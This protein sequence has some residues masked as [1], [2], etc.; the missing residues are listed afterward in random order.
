M[1][2]IA[3]IRSRVRGGVP[4]DA[5]TGCQVESVARKTTRDGKPYLDVALADATDR[6]SLRVWSDHP[7]FERVSDFERGVFIAVGGEFTVGPFGL[8]ARRWRLRKLE[9]AEIEALVGGSPELRGR[10]ERDFA[11]IQALIAG[12]ADP[13][14]RG[15]GTLFLGEHGA[16]FRRSAAARSYHHAR[17]GGLV[18]HTAQM[19]RCADAVARVYPQLNRDLLIAGALFHDC[20]KLWENAV[21]EAGFAMPFSLAGEMLGHISIGIELVNALW[22]KLPPMAPGDTTAGPGA[23]EVRLHLLHLIASHHGELEFGSPVVPKTPEAAALHY[24]D[25]LDAKLEMFAGGYA[26]APE[27]AAGILERVRPLPGNLV[28]PLPSHPGTIESPPPA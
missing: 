26:S 13:R 22:R 25:N 14:L 24:I 28:R 5:E 8:E 15:L 4:A 12:L 20:G 23:E 3:E 10:Q 27:L 18:E 7:S 6:F 19:M 11:D 1:E 9:P 2:S 16:R 17:R 21:E